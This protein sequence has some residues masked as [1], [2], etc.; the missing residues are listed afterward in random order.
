MLKVR[1]MKIKHTSRRI[2]QLIIA[3][4]LTYLF[5]IQD[6]KLAPSPYFTWSGWFDPLMGFAVLIVN[7]WP[8]L[9][10]LSL[11][12]VLLALY[13]SRFFCGWFCPVGAI[14]DLLADGKRLIHWREQTPGIN[15]KKWLNYIRWVLFG[16][17]IG[18][19]LSKWF[20]A[21]MINPLVLWPREIHRLTSGLIPWTLVGMITFGLLTFPRFWCRYIC[22]AGSL[23]NLI[24][25]ISK[26]RYIIGDGCKNCELCVSSCPVQNIGPQLQIGDDCLHCGQCEYSCPVH[27]IDK[28]NSVKNSINE[29]RRDFLV[30]TAA[31]LGTLAIA[32]INKTLKVEAAGLTPKRWPRLLRP[33]GA[34]G[35][36][37]LA[38]TCNRC[39]QCL[40]VCPTKV[41]I[42]SGLE[43]KLSG[44]WTPRFVP[45][46]GRCMFC[47]A[48]G[49]VC[50]TQALVPVPVQTVKLGRPTIDH[51]KCLAW[52]NHTK[53]LLCAET[54]PT[55]SIRIDSSE[56]P[57]IDLERCN[58]CG[59][60]EAHCPV[61][62]SAVILTYVGE[63][64]RTLEA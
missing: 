5:L 8:L 49:Q 24:S 21:L 20:I 27:C 11:A 28:R 48:C 25:R 9:I 32:I 51:T 54:C 47:M 62:G 23:L 38:T 45:R 10:I 56:R 46:L 53:C 59:S 36:K 7:H 16:G 40:Q 3:I 57:V 34:L 4:A 58:G 33:P 41:L 26:K 6:W 35:E 18:L 44:L 30:G 64:R 13:A 14:L 50:P 42:P 15:I 31:G 55:F 17:A 39:G 52:A 63:T 1:V 22:P 19:I 12:G 2:I 61:E 37:A 60:C 29:V 43:A